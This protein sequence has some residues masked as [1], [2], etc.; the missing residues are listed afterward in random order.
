MPD[1]DGENF[2]IRPGIYPFPLEEVDFGT[3]YCFERMDISIVVGGAVDGIAGCCT[4]NA[5]G[6]QSSNRL[7]SVLHSRHKEIHRAIPGR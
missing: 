6:G 2:L 7:R 1:I 4:Q 3:I 5:A